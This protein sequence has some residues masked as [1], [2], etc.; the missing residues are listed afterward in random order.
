MA[1]LEHVNMTVR[2]PAATAAWL[3]EVFGWR[4][5]WQGEAINRGTTIHV[6]EENTYLALYVPAGE[7]ADGPESYGLRGGLNH[8]GVVVDDL[9][10]TE[11]RVLASG[12]RPHHHAD[13]E[14]GRR[15]Y[16]RDGD[17]IEWEVVS[18]G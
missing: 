9:D 12:F 17:G 14:P 15:F 13:Y 1:R 8:V 4:I 6:G 11:A 5:R 7:I 10:A 2:D 3:R 18:Y 16:F